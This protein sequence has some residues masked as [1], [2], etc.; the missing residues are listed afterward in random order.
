TIA[1]LDGVRSA[2]V[3]IVQP[4]NRLLLTEQGIRPS[5]SV[6][7]ELATTS[8]NV[9]AVNSVRHLVANSVQGLAPDDVAV[10]DQKGRVLSAELEQDPLLATASSQIRY[11]QQVEDYFARKVETMLK[12]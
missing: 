5:A 9:E 7:L 10:V 3:M 11:R 6:F 4:E 2:R 1:Q 8:M 12:P